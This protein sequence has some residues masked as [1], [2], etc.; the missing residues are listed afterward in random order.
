MKKIGRFIEKKKYQP[1]S[2]EIIVI[3]DVIVIML[4]IELIGCIQVGWVPLVLE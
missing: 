1:Y 4:I 2:I 3:I